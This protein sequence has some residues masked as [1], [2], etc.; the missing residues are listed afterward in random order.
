MGNL[1]PKQLVEIK[2]MVA[3]TYWNWHKVAS[4]L[5]RIKYLNGEHTINAEGNIYLPELER[6]IK[7]KHRN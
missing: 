7:G 2:L 3:N 6:F 5:L 1:T 4:K